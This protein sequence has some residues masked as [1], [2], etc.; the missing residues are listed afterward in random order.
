MSSRIAARYGKSL[1]QFATEK[2]VS[3][4]VY[5]DMHE[6]IHLSA[7]SVDFR[8]LVKSP[9]ID[10]GEKS[11]VFDALFASFCEETRGFARMC[12]SRRREAYLPDMAQQYVDLYDDSKGVARATVV[13]AI[14]LNESVLEQLRRYLGSVLQKNEV[15]LENVTDTSVIGGLVVRYKDRLLDMSVSRELR[16]LRKELILNN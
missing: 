6:L 3:D 10:A 13:S 14:P 5:A 9:V 12:A 4:R 1:L 15:Q 16:Q 2:G 7:S 8:E 11:K